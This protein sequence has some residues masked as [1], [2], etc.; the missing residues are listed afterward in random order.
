LQRGS[1]SETQMA[2]R[3]VFRRS[4]RTGASLGCG[5]ERELP[6]GGCGDYHGG[7]VMVSERLPNGERAMKLAKWGLAILLASPLTIPSLASAQSQDTAQS[8]QQ[9]PL[10]AAARRAR[11]QKKDQPKAAKVWDNDNIPSGAGSVS[12]VGNS[13][14]TD[15]AASDQQQGNQQHDQ[16]QAANSN[17]QAQPSDADK[18]AKAAE[19][20]GDKRQLESL[21][22]DLD[23]LQRKLV[24]DQQTYYSK[25]DYSSDKAGAAA[26]K[27]EQDQIA[28]KQQ[29][30]DD[31]QKKM[32]DLQSQLDAASSSPSSPANN[33]NQN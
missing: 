13:G 22:T 11:E 23:I 26:L 1:A 25:P 19:L 14:A 5:H 9:D 18:A 31:L 4:M 8:G 2:I 6:S 24:L 27:D 29:Q 28:A 12:V 33:Q 20:D 32:D 17:A 21:K 16:G 30:I 10:A 15:Q 3:R 7:V